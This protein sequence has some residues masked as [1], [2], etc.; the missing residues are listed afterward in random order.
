MEH[1]IPNGYT[2]C[3]SLSCFVFGLFLPVQQALV[4]FKILL[5]NVLPVPGALVFFSST[6]TSLFIEMISYRRLILKIH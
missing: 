5:Q 2:C 4:K 6:I 3:V 1:N